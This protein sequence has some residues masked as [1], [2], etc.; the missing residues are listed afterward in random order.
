MCYIFLHFPFSCGF[1]LQ[2][3]QRGVQA[4]QEIIGKLLDGLNLQDGQPVVIIDCLPN[5]LLGHWYEPNTHAFWLII[6]SKQKNPNQNTSTAPLPNSCLDL[7]SGRMPAPTC[8]CN[9]WL[10]MLRDRHTTTWG[11]SCK[12]THR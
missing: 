12:M 10:T 4:T 5:R 11:C 6:M 2:V 3:Q 1:T 7:Q 9:H 8:N